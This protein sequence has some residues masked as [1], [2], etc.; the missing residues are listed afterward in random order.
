MMHLGRDL[1]VREHSRGNPISQHVFGSILGVEV[2]AG[3]MTG[4]EN[5][6]ERVQRRV[7]TLRHGLENPGSRRGRCS[8]DRKVKGG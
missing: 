3:Q 1:L 6:S 5:R 8:L 2:L 4:L 7:C